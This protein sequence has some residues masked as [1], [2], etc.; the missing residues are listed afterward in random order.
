[1]A[2]GAFA[3]HALDVNAAH[4]GLRGKG[5][6]GGMQTLQI[7]LAQVKALFAS[8]TMLRPSGVSSAS[9]ELGGIGQGFSSTPAR[10]ELGGLAVAEGDGPGFIQ[11]QNVDIARGFNGA[12]GGD[13]VGAEHTAHPGDADGRQQPPMVVGIRHTSSG[14]QHG[15]ADRVP[16]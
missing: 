15:D 7:A 11:Q 8:I 6:K 13:H 5:D 4:T 1:M 9:E 10:Q 14:H 12:A 2:S 3:D 16:P